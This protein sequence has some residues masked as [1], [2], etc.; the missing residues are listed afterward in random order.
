MKSL[1]TLQRCVDRMAID[2]KITPVFVKDSTGEIHIIPK[3]VSE[4]DLGEQSFFL[5]YM[6]KKIE[7]GFQQ[8]L[9][10]EEDVPEDQNML[11]Q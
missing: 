4:L 9:S 5:V 7:A 3:D 10:E 1:D 2:N 6:G 11:H 8:A